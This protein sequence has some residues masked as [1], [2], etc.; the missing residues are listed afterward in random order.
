MSFH[1]SLQSYHPTSLMI[2]ITVA[3]ATVERNLATSHVWVFTSHF[4]AGPPSSSPLLL[5]NSIV[6]GFFEH[7]HHVNGPSW[8]ALVLSVLFV[9]WVFTW[10]VDLHDHIET[11]LHPISLCVTEPNLAGQLSMLNSTAVAKIYN[12]KPNSLKIEWIGIFSVTKLGRVQCSFILT[13]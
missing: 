13:G 3:L 8:Y 11:Y 1:V 4:S 6:Q 2:L 7:C 5:A 12:Y 9:W 10:F